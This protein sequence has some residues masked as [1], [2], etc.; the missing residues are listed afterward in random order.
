MFLT[1][2][3]W[4]RH[5][6]A[7]AV[8]LPM[9]AMS[10]PAQ[11]APLTSAQQSVVQQA[12][13]PHVAESGTREVKNF[14]TD[15][16]F[17]QGDVTD[18]Q[19]GSIDDSGWGWVNL[20]HN[21]KF[22]TPEDVT[23]YLGA[24]WY[25]KKFTVGA[26]TAGKK[27]SIDFEAAMQKAEVWLNGT[28]IAT[29]VGG[30][31]PFS[32]DV[33]DKLLPGENLIAV[34]IDTR[35]NAEFGP[36]RT[37]VDFRY[38]GG[39][40]RDVTMT[41]TDRVHITDA[42]SKNEVAGGGLFITT[43]TVDPASS[44]VQVRT[45]VQNDTAASTS[46]Q[47]KTEILDASNTVVAT[48]TSTAQPLGA[49]KSSVIQQQL[50]VTNAKLWHPNSPNL[51]H[52]RVSVLAGGA[53]VDQL[54]EQFGIRKIEWRHDG[55]FIN[56]A[57]FKAIGTNKHQEIY[58]LGNAVPNTSIYEDV[59]RVK[60]AGFDFIRTSHYPNDP[61]FYDAAD[62]L[63]VLVLNSMTGWQTFNNTTAF[64]EN[65]Y[66]EL[67]DMIRRDRN[68]PSVVAWETSL[69]E[70]NYSAEWAQ[71]TNSIAHE[72]Y[73]GNQ[74]FTAG[75]LDYFDIYV[76]ASQHDIR[77]TTKTKPILISE[78]GDWDYGGNS[79]TSRVPRENYDF[80]NQSRNSLS[81][82]ANHQEG[83]N[84]NL[85]MDWFSADALWDFADMS[86]YNPG[87]SL[88]GVTDYYRIPK[89]GTYLFKSQRN[90][91][92]LIPGVDSGPMAFIANTW[93]ANSP[94]SVKVFSNAEQVRLFKNGTLVATQSPDTTKDTANLPHPPFTFDVGA[95]SAGEL[96]A[97]ALIGGVVVATHS[98]K[99][100][101][102]ASKI[103]LSKE[104][105]TPL[106]A[107]GSDAR[108]VHI[109]VQDANGTV[110]YNDGGT[111]NVSVT[112]PG[113]I[114]GPTTLTMKGGQLAVWVR[115]KRA[116]GEITLTASRAGLAAGTTTI[117][118]DE[119]PGLPA[120]QYDDGE[121]SGTNVATGSVA[122]ASSSAAGT[123]AGAA[124][125][126][127]LG[128]SWKSG[129]AAG[130]SWLMLD[131]K[132]RHD[133]TGS[134]LVWD[135]S[136][137]YPYLI[138][139]S[140]DGIVWDT[141][142]DKSGPHDAGEKVS[143]TW[144]RS[145]RYVRVVFPE[146][147]AT[148]VAGVAE[149][150]LFGSA[151]SAP[152]SLDIAQ[153]K[154]GVMA[155]N[156]A[157][158]HEPAVANNGNP[159]QYW[160]G[161][162][163]GNTWWSVDLGAR[164]QLTST[165]V[166][167]LDGSRAY[168]YTIEVSNDGENYY[169]VA[170]KSANTVSGNESQDAF[171]AVARYV[172]ISIAG[173]SSDKSPVGMYNFKTLGFPVADVVARKSS[174]A[175]S[176]ADGAGAA[177]A[178]DTAVGTAWRS[179]KGEAAPVWSVDLGANFALNGIDVKL[180]AGSVRNFTVETSL[181]G[182]A[183]TPAPATASSTGSLTFSSTVSARHVRVKFTG[184]GAGESAGL[185]SVAG[186]AG[187]QNRNLALASENPAVTVSATYSNTGGGDSLSKVNDGIIATASTGETKNLWT[188]WIATPRAEDTITV[189][190]G[191]AR[192]VSSAE[193]YVFVDSGAPTPAAV[194]V[195]YL[196][197]SDWK[198]VPS[199]AA[200][201]A[202][203]AQGKNVVQFGAVTTTKVRFVM[204]AGK[205]A[206]GSLGCIAISELRVLGTDAALPKRLAAVEVAEST[207]MQQ[208][209]ATNIAEPGSKIRLVATGR[210][211]AFADVRATWE[212]Q[213]VAGTEPVASVDANGVV[214]GLRPG[215][216]TVLAVSSD[217]WNVVGALDVSVGEPEA[218]VPPTT[219]P[220][221]TTP[222]TTVPPTTTPPTTDQSERPSTSPAG[223][224]TA[225]AVTPSEGGSPATST[226]AGAAAD[227]LASTGVDSKLTILAAF[228]GLMLVAGLGA[229]VARNRG[230]QRRS[231]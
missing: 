154:P 182:S 72:E 62:K 135:K 150:K 194:T 27:V 140:E 144:L 116:A 224:A 7:V 169:T 185:E 66:K 73:P 32:M 183:W 231:H 166:T 170:D 34:R 208:R 210:P 23:E 91:D 11:A 101:G 217:G 76:G 128:T 28:K 223:A 51:Y 39:L 190:F 121:A 202:Q 161:G 25:R 19:L 146:N 152:A 55:L 213:A 103:A 200:T 22:N 107:D 2:G 123:T 31:T 93:S 187:E 119:V 195:Q 102:T 206:N 134:T 229:M 226:S 203:P 90:A 137:A 225:A 59:K 16:K 165:L 173:D 155:S 148:G 215:K 5:V 36:G 97:E 98:V 115:A 197:G 88:M 13:A 131:L 171:S 52:A 175:T 189:D 222:P 162:R 100:A 214:T 38:F 181:D 117:T 96:R 168:K 220:P 227:D 49:G 130:N 42:V 192:T 177:L 138:Q 14:N 184:V 132:T 172:R 69:N 37:G 156:F 48:G 129:T 149:F 71:K 109:A 67:R 118:S 216:A 122:T 158:G 201:P 46:V 157:S 45:D 50:T 105:Q 87:A 56:G 83:L 81:Q 199:A 75:W 127:N 179:A 57:R 205:L 82:A 29:H 61:A 78:W 94:T 30:Y 18:G 113:E 211:A 212:I 58:G 167:W 104:T 147:A 20:P 15:W 44:T 3:R 163:G 139:Y 108:L 74:M 70:S 133:L 60:D 33:T 47:V 136:A 143:D 145:G 64:K 89:F 35:P 24:A 188:N 198:N 180:A 79:S 164:H 8:L 141:A 124:V 207:G 193:F 6:L 142:L 68:H 84:A 21:I 80:T 228:A 218:T 43:P 4:G 151:S 125:D 112:G 178:N 77:K 159:A 40:Y 219:V 9:V 12:P 114:V 209:S 120:P 17:N 106:H 191:G 41:V 110:A 153:E 63:G 99:T 10:V 54:T 126:Q 53:V 92:V 95:Y 65:S 186:Y 230:R 85:G 86:G 174:M 111:V 1:R 221:T 196:D 204:A 160:Q 26:E 176:S